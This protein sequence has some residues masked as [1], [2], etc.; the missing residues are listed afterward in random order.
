MALLCVLVGG[1]CALVPRFLKKHEKQGAVA[2]GIY[3]GE[4]SA[5]SIVGGPAGGGGGGTSDIVLE[6]TPSHG[7]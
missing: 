6:H 7:S 1:G 3:S 5:G 4:A 2:E